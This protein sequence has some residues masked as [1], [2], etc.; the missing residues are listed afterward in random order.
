M[1]RQVELSSCCCNDWPTSSEVGFFCPHNLEA[2]FKQPQ[3]RNENVVLTAD[4]HVANQLSRVA[5]IPI[6]SAFVLELALQCRFYR[7]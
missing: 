6:R 7:L 1:F 2:N 3:E 5:T 4:L